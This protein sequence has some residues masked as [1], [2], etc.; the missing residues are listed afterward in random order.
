MS[1]SNHFDVFDIDG[2]GTPEV[3]GVKY[4]YAYSLNGKKPDKMRAPSDRR[5]FYQWLYKEGYRYDDQDRVIFEEVS[6]SKF[7]G[8]RAEEGRSYKQI[9]L[10]EADYSPEN[11]QFFEIKP[12]H[13]VRELRRVAS[14]Y[15]V[16]YKKLDLK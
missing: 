8:N 15:A 14:S 2:N 12:I 6:I 9:A 3:M 10:Y 5:G 4:F 11:I 1:K 16:D 13:F 7:I